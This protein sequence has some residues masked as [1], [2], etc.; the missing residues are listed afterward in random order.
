MPELHVKAIIKK[1]KY[2][3]VCHENVLY[4]WTA[5]DFLENGVEI[6]R[7]H[8]EN[9]EQIVWSIQEFR[10]L[11]PRAKFEGKLITSLKKL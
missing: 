9:G 2:R 8:D 10:K 1:E 5:E 4:I 6:N 3:I 11:Y 7:K